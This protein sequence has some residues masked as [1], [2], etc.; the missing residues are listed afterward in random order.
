MTDQKKKKKKKQVS[1]A[2]EKDDGDN[3]HINS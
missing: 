3:P 2:Y 1:D